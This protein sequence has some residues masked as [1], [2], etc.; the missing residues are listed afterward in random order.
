MTAQPIAW[1]LAQM[2]L[3][4]LRETS[5]GKRRET[6]IDEFDLA[7]EHLGPGLTDLT[8]GAA[9]E[10]LQR[11]GLDRMKD[12]LVGEAVAAGMPARQNHRVT[13]SAKGPEPHPFRAECSCG[14]RGIWHVKRETAEGAGDRHAA[15]PRLHP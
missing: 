8:A 2:L 11:A 14:F 13:I 3:V 6:I 12:A 15:T 4:A 9:T 5:A 7:L 10:S 1:S